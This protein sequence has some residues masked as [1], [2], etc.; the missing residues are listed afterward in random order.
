[1][2]LIPLGSA[3]APLSFDGAA[4]D[5][6][7]FAGLLAVGR[8]FM[9][10]AALDT[11]SPFEGMGGARE[12]TFACLAEPVLFFGFLVL[13]KITHKLDLAAM[14]SGS[15]LVEWGAY[16]PS[17][18]LVLVSW[19][20][21]LLVEN[22]RVPFDDPNTHLELTMIHEVIVLDHS[23]P[24]FGLIL[25]G[26]ALKLFVFAA[27][28]VRLVV[29]I[30][31]GSIAADWALFTAG[32]FAVSVAVG[33]WESLM[34]RLRMPSVPTRLVLANVLAAFALVLLVRKP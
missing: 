31:T 27:L 4:G 16:G 8:F 2:L 29:P 22:S 21:V 13:A 9:V 11:G 12:V 7:L 15:V 30:D 1:V 20:I 28:V 10:L 5:F 23:G 33:V 32:V 18:L 25:Y 34:A 6:V 3:A 24:A 26:A 14:L 17:L 19:F